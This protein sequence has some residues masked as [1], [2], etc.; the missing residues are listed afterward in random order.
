MAIRHVWVACC[1]LWDRH[2]C[3]L[4][5]LVSCGHM[6]VVVHGWGLFSV[7]GSTGWLFCSWAT[8]V[9]YGCWVPFMGA[10]SLSVGTGSLLVGVGLSII[11]GEACSCGQVL[12]GCWFVVCGRGGDV[13]CAGW[14]PLARLDEMRVG[15]LTKQQQQ[16]TTSMSSFVVW[17]PPHSW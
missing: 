1:C 9:I 13:L 15:V 16:M 7:P 8:V 11:G 14:S 17:L 12:C 2:R 5:I 10:G 4:G 6:A 3:L